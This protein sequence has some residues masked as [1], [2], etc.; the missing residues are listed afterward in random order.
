MFT[1]G[2]SEKEKDIR[3]QVLQL[4]YTSK[5]RFEICKWLGKISHH[6]H[7]ESFLF[8]LTVF[9][10][11]HHHHTI[12]LISKHKHK[13]STN[14][15]KLQKIRLFSLFLSKCFLLFARVE[16]KENCRVLKNILW[17]LFDVLRALVSIVQPTSAR[18]ELRKW[19]KE[20]KK[21]VE[22]RKILLRPFNLLTSTTKCFSFDSSFSSLFCI[23]F[24]SAELPST[25]VFHCCFL[26]QTMSFLTCYWMKNLI[27]FFA[28]QNTIFNFPDETGMS[29]Q[30]QILTSKIPN[31][32]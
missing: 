26:Q 15:K 3:R 4:L 21:N 5:Q 10:L 20:R 28:K 25:S 17:L 18:W 29:T 13:Q 19:R 14:G 32:W 30:L 24:L 27:L 22:K 16:M 6:N 23:F 12:H 1:W 7:R 2:L 8:I 31:I 11:P 9:E